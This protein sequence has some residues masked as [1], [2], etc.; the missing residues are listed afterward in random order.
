[1]IECTPDGHVTISDG[2]GPIVTFARPTFGQ[3]RGVGEKVRQYVEW[4]DRISAATKVVD[5]AEASKKDRDAA[6]KILDSEGAADVETVTVPLWRH[7]LDTVPHDGD[8]PDDVDEWPAWLPIDMTAPIEAFNFWRHRP[9]VS[10]P[11]RT[12]R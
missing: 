2:D 9:K 8:L 6:Q 3:W 12:D 5:D 7:L 11:T 1:M 4:F 10:G